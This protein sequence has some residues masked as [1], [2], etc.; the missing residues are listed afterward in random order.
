MD[1]LESLV[2]TLMSQGAAACPENPCMKENQSEE[3]T[4]RLP[5]KSSSGSDS[6]IAEAHPEVGVLH[7]DDQHSIYK[8]STHWSQILAE[9][10]LPSSRV[11]GQ[12]CES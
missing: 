6:P 10:T 7:V 8:G 1:E 2:T 9:V 12:I 11:F 4:A 5:T 3:P